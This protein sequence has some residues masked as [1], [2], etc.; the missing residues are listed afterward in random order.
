VEFYIAFFE[1][2]GTDLLQIIEESRRSERISDGLKSTF[3]ALIPK[4]D[5]PSSFDDF[6]PI[7]LCNCT[8]KIVA[9]IIAN[10]INPILSLHIS[11]EQFAFLHNRKVHEVIGTAQELLHS[12]LL[13]KLKGMIMKIDL[14]KAFDRIN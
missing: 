6:I 11:H 12:I 1:S 7:S 13:R 14:S 8:Y 5:K 3:I 9:K 2:L 10:R 4:A